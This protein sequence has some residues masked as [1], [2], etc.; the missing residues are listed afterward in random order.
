M[1]TFFEDYYVASNMALILSGDFDAQQVMPI[2]EK[3]F[4]RIRSGNAPKQEKVMLPPFNGRETMK[5]KDSRFPLLRRWGLVSGCFGQ[6]RG[7]GSPL[8]IAV[9]LLENNA[10]GTGLSGQ[11]DGGT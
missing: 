9:N 2:L 5:G 10:N 11:T 3:A 4:S 6:P 8:N 1:H 7:P